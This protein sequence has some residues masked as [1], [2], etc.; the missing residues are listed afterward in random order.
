MY[1]ILPIFQIKDKSETTAVNFQK[2]LRVN[3]T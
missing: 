3:Q 2:N 1:R